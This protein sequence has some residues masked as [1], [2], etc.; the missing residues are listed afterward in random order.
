MLLFLLS[1]FFVFFFFFFLCLRNFLLR[2]CRLVSMLA[3]PFCFIE[4]I[5]YVC[6]APSS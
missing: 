1:V 3:F 6:Q 5:I 4:S 2:R